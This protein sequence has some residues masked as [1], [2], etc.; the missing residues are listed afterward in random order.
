MTSPTLT[1]LRTARA[2]IR[3]QISDM[4]RSDNFCYTNHRV[5]NL[6]LAE[7]TFDRQINEWLSSAENRP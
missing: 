1:E 7:Q 5:D 4:E 6:L 2:I 3:Q